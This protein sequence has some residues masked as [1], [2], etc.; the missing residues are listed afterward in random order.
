ML[1]VVVIGCEF[2][3]TL[4]PVRNSSPLR[5]VLDSGIALGRGFCDMNSD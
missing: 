2:A 5:L 3:K 1:L 4:V